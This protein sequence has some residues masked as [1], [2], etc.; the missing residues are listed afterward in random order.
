[1]ARILGAM[2]PA[3]AY[4]QLPVQA[5]SYLA[6]GR[7]EL[8]YNP[9]STSTW[10]STRAHGDVLYLKAG[11]AGD[12]PSLA[13]ERDRCRWLAG[14]GAPVPEVIDYGC[15]DH[16]EWLATAALH[17]VDATA[18]Q[19][20]DDPRRTV[21]ILAEGLRAFHEIDPAGCPFDSR[22]PA[23]LAHVTARV[24]AGA[25]DREGFHEIHRHLDPT[26]ALARLRDIALDDDQ[27][28]VCHGDYCL[29]NLLIDGGEV[30][31]YLDLG[32]VGL[33]DRWRDLAV[34]TWSMTWNMGPGH[35]DLF[36]AAYGIEW[37]HARRDFYRLLYDLES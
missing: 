10:R 31:G 37:D 7:T 33:A 16:V 20:L 12:H 2:R 17:G 21:P 24:A 6:A 29:P 27:I 3:P 23:A 34:A 4:E 5:Q 32:E 19:H 14:R 15:D 13:G 28:V 9:Y 11:P 26:A 1:M 22:T 30:V 35:G 36:L 18:P 25:V 8:I